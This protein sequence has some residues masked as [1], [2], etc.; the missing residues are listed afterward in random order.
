M[1]LR[2]GATGD[3]ETVAADALFVL[4]DAHLHTD[5]LPDHARR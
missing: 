2:D 1:P 4:L 3:E 5:R